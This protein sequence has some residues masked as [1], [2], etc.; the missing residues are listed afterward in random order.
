MRR[1][2]MLGEVRLPGLRAGV[3]GGEKERWEDSH[4][5]YCPACRRRCYRMEI[6][7][8]RCPFILAAGGSWRLATAVCA[9]WRWAETMTQGGEVT[10][11]KV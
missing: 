10:A 8:E 2:R 11:G 9:G 1:R 7:P 6:K 4:R 5:K 3:Q